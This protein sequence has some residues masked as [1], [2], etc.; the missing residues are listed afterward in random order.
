MSLSAF[1]E[2][3]LTMLESHSFYGL[4]IVQALSQLR[5]GGVAQGTIYPILKKL[6]DREYAKADW[7]E[8]HSAGARRKYYSIT[9]LGKE[10]LFNQ[11]QYRTRLSR[12]V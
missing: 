1:E 10:A 9:T 12:W 4:Q 8:G 11:K 7:G 5:E 3:I 6:E 2:D